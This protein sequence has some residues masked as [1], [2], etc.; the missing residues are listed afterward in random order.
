MSSP[1][2]L[3]GS[4]DGVTTSQLFEALSTNSRASVVTPNRRLASYLKGQFDVAKQLGGNHAWATPDI[5]PIT[6]FLERSYLALNLRG[7]APQSSQ[8]LDIS[9]SQLLWEQVVRASDISSYLLSV[10]RTARQAA[11]AWSVAHAWALFPGMRQ[12]TL[13]EDAAV[14]L[15]WAQRFERLCRERDVIDAAVLPTIMAASMQNVTEWN[16]VLPQQLFTAGFDIITPQQRHFFAACE[17]RGISVQHVRLLSQEQRREPLQIGQALPRCRRVEF[18]NEDAEIRGCAAWVRQCTLANPRHRI[19]I[20]VPDLRAKRG[21]VVRALSDALHPGRRA[22]SPRTEPS[23]FNVSLGLA[24]D[25]YA[26]V[27]DAISLIALSQNRSIPFLEVSALLRS[28]FIAGADAESDSRARLDGALREVVSP[29]ISLFALQRRLKVANETNL[30]RVAAQCPTLLRLIDAAASIGVPTSPVASKPSPRDWSRHFGKILLGW[31]FPGDAVLESVDYQVLEKFRDAL[32][33]LATIEAVQPRMR[34]DEAL[35]HLRSIVSDTVFQPEIA[36]NSS[37]PIQVL[38]ILESA[39]QTFDALW[40]TGLSEEAWPLAARPNPFVPAALQRAAGVTEAS[41]AA[42]LA[43]D[44]RITEDWRRCAPDVIF[45]HAQTG[46]GSNTSDQHRSA[47]ALTRDVVLTDLKALIG[48]SSE[49]DYAR[50]LFAMRRREP[51]TEGPLPALPLPTKVAGGATV[52]RDQAACPFRAFAR[53]RLGARTLG[54]PEAGLDVAE[55]GTLLHRV[56]SLVWTRIGTQAQLIAM[57]E[58]AR[59]ILVHEMVKKAINETQAA[60]TDSLSGRFAE[61]EQARLISLVT[62]WLTYEQERAPFEVAACEQARDVELSGLSM[63]LRLD[64]LDRLADGTY[65]LIDY[66]TGIAKATGW[67]G[68]R[69]DEPQLP[70]YFQTSA[71][72]ISVLAFARV[73]KGA[74]G[75]VFGFEGVSAAEGLLPDVTP[76]EAKSGMEKKGYFSWDVLTAEWESSLR[77][78][79]GNFIHGDALVDPK[80]GSLTCSQCDLQGLCRISEVNGAQISD[81]DSADGDENALA[82]HGIVTGLIVDG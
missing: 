8:L 28:P 49:T 73:K 12:M 13:S 46:D 31:G 75:K 74:R 58:A 67:L 40:V 10:T 29:E 1:S 21:D 76:I 25:E 19:A 44:Q 2:T 24:L 50:A 80:H 72:T 17:K 30:L 51:I 39:G 60:G 27:S 82:G 81:E 5:L 53:H 69:L 66:K 55:R 18:A 34:A 38:G 22:R 11:T 4:S 6:T 3:N 20:V 56:L 14:F 35:N 68:E 36:Q 23:G 43:L 9:Q 57:D 64:R 7:D 32:N 52:L 33:A 45:S 54:A 37:A 78:L 70:L 63:R 15:G 48:A 77:T 61:I 47:S 26:L 41:A 79:V 65:A 59:R 71:Q 16:E 62:E 42:S